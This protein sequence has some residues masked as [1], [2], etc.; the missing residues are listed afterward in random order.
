M[1]VTTAPMTYW[2][3]SATGRWGKLDALVANRLITSGETLYSVED[4]IKQTIAECN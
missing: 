2:L 1:L 4:Y 3:V